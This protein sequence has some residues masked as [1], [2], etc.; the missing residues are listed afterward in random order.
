MYATT[1][2]VD[3]VCG[4][5]VLYS[6]MGAYEDDDAAPAEA[7]VEANGEELGDCEGGGEVIELV[8][9]CQRVV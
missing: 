3:V 2:R 4:V 1:L 7:V 6:G 8:G 9:R 5:L